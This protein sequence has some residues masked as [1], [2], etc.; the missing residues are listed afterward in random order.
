MTETTHSEDP[1]EPGAGRPGGTHQAGQAAAVLYQ[2]S[3]VIGGT[4]DLGA[5]LRSA[6]TAVASAMNAT[7][8]TIYLRA[9]GSDELYFHTVQSQY[10]GDL[11]DLRLPIDEHSVAGWVAEHHEM[12]SIREAY[13]DARFNSAYDEATGFRTH[14]ILCAPLLVRGKLVGVVQILNRRDGEPFDAWDSE[15]L[16]GVASLVAVAVDSAAQHEAL[17]RGERLATVGQTVAGLAHCIKNI[18]NSLQGGSYILEQRLKGPETSDELR[19]AWGIVA[20]NL[21][22]LSDVVLDMLSYAK[23]RDPLRRP[24]RIEDVC[25]D[26]ADFL[27][28]QARGANVELTCHSDPA[29][30]EVMIDETSI[31][32][33]LMNLVGNS[34]DAC[35]DAGGTVELDA[36][37]GDS[38]DILEIR[39]ADNGCGIEPN[40]LGTVFDPLI[41]TKG[42]KGT[43]LGL[44]VTRK[45]VEE[46]GGTIHVR[47]Q[48]GEGTVFQIELPMPA[49]A[50]REPAE[51]GAAAPEEG[52][53]P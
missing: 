14:S 21:S 38:A 43:G 19:K 40:M 9:A 4:L 23:R 32:R 11:R 46:H 16:K 7:A 20:R 33:C 39:V 47:S 48:V 18:L 34:I 26:V 29:L 13:G 42:G 8:C 5:V 49:T 53:K 45:I 25:Q 17:M 22:F 1:P 15:L 28:E 12:L 24:C 27:A 30:G 2:V 37:P 51:P 36:G 50:P 44:A 41:S 6:M 35:S 52:A 3:Q 10:A 31:R